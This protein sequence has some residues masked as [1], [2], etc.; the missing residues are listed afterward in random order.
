MKT[1][2]LLC[3]EAGRFLAASL[4]M[5]YHFSDL[6]GGMRGEH[7]LGWAFRAGHCGVEFFFV[8]SGYLIASQHTGQSGAAAAMRFVLRRA[9][10]VYPAFL[11]VTVA[12]ATMWLVLPLGRPAPSGLLDPMRLLA[13]MTLAPATAPLLGVSW[14][15]RQEAM[16]YAIFGLAI[17]VGRHGWW[18]LATW[19]ALV[20]ACIFLIP[21]AGGEGL[22]P[23]L[24]VTNLGFGMGMLVARGQL[25]R[26]LPRVSPGVWL[27]CGGG[28][29]AGLAGVEWV[30]GRHIPVS[31]ALPFGPVASPLVYSVAAMM[32]VQGL[33]GWE[34]AG[35]RVPAP[36]L[37]ALLGGGSYM[38]YLTHGLV[39]S[40]LVR[41]LPAGA[42]GDLVLLALAAAAI[43]AALAAYVLVERPFLAWGMRRR[44]PQAAVPAP[45]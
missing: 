37:V 23:L 32:L 16:F 6:V 27:F 9:W 5:L 22:A 28:L 3:L 18:L 2:R 24:G 33:V 19:Q 1:H 26:I 20:A 7:P 36:R 12:V 29:L 21:Q 45:G 41:V 15:L 17:L 31:T 44:A 35:G 25:T 10:R 30:L 39:G 38:L 42:G 13:D 43:Q 4:V 34:R 40:A 11:A 8:L 14:S